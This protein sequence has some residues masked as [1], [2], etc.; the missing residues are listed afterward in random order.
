MFHCSQ[1]ITNGKSIN[2][3]NPLTIKLYLNKLYWYDNQF[4]ECYNKKQ[5]ELNY[6]GDGSTRMRTEI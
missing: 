3:S 5:K 2:K 1:E 4:S 6:A